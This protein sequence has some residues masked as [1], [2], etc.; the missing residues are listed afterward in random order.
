M[1][2]LH[3]LKNS[4]TDKYSIQSEYNETQTAII[5]NDYKNKNIFSFYADIDPIMLKSGNTI[6]RSYGLNVDNHHY[7]L[8]LGLDSIVARGS[9]H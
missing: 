3:Y 1:E 4:L 7:D 9:S 2:F 8:N 5:L 6:I